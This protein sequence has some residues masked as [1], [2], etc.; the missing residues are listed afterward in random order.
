MVISDRQRLLLHLAVIPCK[1]ALRGLLVE[2][3]YVL[4]GLFHRF[5]DLVERHAVVAIGEGGED[6]GV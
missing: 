2:R 1:S 3:R 4:A 5:H 6:V